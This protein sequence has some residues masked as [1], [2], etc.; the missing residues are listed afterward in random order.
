VSA[1]IVDANRKFTIFRRKRRPVRFRLERPVAS[2][3]LRPRSGVG[4]AVGDDG[5]PPT[6]SAN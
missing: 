6:R 3:E 1:A 2:A 5:K 4:A